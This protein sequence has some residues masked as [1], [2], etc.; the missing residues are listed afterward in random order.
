M[1]QYNLQNLLVDVQIN[2]SKQVVEE[3][4]FSKLE[5]VAGADVSFS[6]NHKAVAA[7]VVLKLDDLEIVEK[8]TLSVE[9]CFPY[10]PG[11]LC[12][13]EADAV[14]SVINAL[15]SDFDVLMVNGHGVMHPRGFGMASHVG[16]LLDVPTIGL[17]KRLIGGSY[18]KE[19]IQ[20]DQTNQELQFIKIGKR[21]VGA[22]FRGIYLSVGHKISLNTAL[23]IVKKTS[24]YKTPEPL[25]HAHMLATG[26]FKNE[27][28]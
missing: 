13:R 4:S 21:V 7:A 20:S 25:R 11:F 28:K 5:N 23:D 24:K 14:I 16:V 18:I 22:F 6:K 27:L 1:Y 9:L 26:T 17:A 3:D 15:E 19:G 10:V 2:L 12:I 8:K